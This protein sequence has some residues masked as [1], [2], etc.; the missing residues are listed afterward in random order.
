MG[1]LIEN[2]ILDYSST[3]LAHHH[4]NYPARDFQRFYTIYSYSFMGLIVGYFGLPV[5]N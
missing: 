2:H 5:D 1:E 3:V 4:V